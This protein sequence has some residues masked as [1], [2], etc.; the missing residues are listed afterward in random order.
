[1]PHFWDNFWGLGDRLTIPLYSATR[2][3]RLEELA[4]IFFYLNAIGMI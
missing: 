4:K 1:M 3:Y 2:G